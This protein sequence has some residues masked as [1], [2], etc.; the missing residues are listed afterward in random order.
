MVAATSVG[1]VDGNV[2]VDL[3]YQ[4]DKR[5]SVDLNLVMSHRGELIE[6]Q[7]AGEEA[8]FSTSQ[9]SGML[10]AG[11]EAI[12]SIVEHQK[13]VIRTLAPQFPKLE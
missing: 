13:Q 2:V 7:G 5:A 12:T 1:I 9:L 6:V 4:E 10:S 3:D 8:T 11:Q